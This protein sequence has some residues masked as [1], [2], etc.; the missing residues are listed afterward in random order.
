MGQILVRN[1]DDAVLDRLKAKAKRQGRSLEEVAREALAGAA[2][3]N[4]DEMLAFAAQM[5]AKTAD[6]EP[7]DVVALIRADRDSDHGHQWP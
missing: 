4:R 7:L 2:R 3:P 1:V 6:R 5:R